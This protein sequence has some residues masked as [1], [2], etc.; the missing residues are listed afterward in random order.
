MSAGLRV[1]A[2]PVKDGRAA[3]DAGDRSDAGWGGPEHGGVNLRHGSAE[4]A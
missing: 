1:A 2:D 3:A 4:V